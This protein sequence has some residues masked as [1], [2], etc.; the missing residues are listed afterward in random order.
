MKCS[1][2]PGLLDACAPAQPYD[3]N[4]ETAKFWAAMHVMIMNAC[5]QAGVAGGHPDAVRDHQR[6][7]RDDGGHSVGA[8]RA[9]YNIAL[10]L[11]IWARMTWHH[12]AHGIT[13]LS[14]KSACQ[15]V[16]DIDGRVHMELVCTVISHAD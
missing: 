10:T 11:E 1:A 7:G 13:V 2:C 16:A 12:G 6:R 5:V 9:H 15:L 8:R 3:R 14:S 4:Q